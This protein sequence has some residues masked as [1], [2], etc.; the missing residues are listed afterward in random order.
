MKLNADRPNG[1]NAITRYG[2]G[3]VIV[4][5]A[6]HRGSCVIPWQGAVTEW[7]IARFESLREEHFAA[8]AEMGPELVI[9]GSGARLRFPAAALLRPLIERRIGIETMDTAA[10]CRTYN[11]L[12]D[13]GRTVVAA[14][15]FESVRTDSA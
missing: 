10:A 3:G 1:P 5:G 13:E 6:E 8:L 15:L 12:L 9:F 4:N 11:V 14:L 7:P 2:P